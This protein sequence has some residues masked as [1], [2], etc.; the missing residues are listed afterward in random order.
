MRPHSVSRCPQLGVYRRSER[1]QTP[2]TQRLQTSTASADAHKRPKRIIAPT[3]YDTHIFHSV[4][5]RSQRINMPTAHGARY[6][7]SVSIHPQ[8]RANIAPAAFQYAH[9][10]SL[11]PQRYGDASVATTLLGIEGIKGGALD[12]DFIPCLTFVGDACLSVI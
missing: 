11:R 1:L 8:R 9:S 12:I 5:I 7:H 6:A 10:A 2:I 4:S 3:T